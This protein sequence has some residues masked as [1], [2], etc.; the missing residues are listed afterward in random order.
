MSW[1]LVVT[2]LRYDTVD[3]FEFIGEIVDH[4]CVSELFLLFINIFLMNVNVRFYWEILNFIIALLF[5]LSL[6]KKV[7]QYLAAINIRSGHWPT[8]HFIKY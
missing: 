2:N 1:A 7:I 4:H 8:K 5:I 3:R 6:K